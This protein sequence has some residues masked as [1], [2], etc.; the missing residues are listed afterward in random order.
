MILEEGGELE[1]NPNDNQND[2]EIG[3]ELPENMYPAE[4]EVND[5]QRRYPQRTR[6]EP[7]RYQAGFS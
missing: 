7:N 5:D 3:D 4:H 2:E 6:L 1:L